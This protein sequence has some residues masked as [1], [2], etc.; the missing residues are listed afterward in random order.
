MAGLCLLIGA[1]HAESTRTPSAQPPVA[2]TVREPAESHGGLLDYELMLTG[3]ASQDQ[4]LPLLLAVHGL[5]GSPERFQGMY[6]AL[7]TPARLV[8]PRAPLATSN[9]GGSWFFFQLDDPDRDAFGRRLHAAAKEV[10]VLLDWAQDHFPTVGKP[11]IT[12]FSQGGMVSLA[13]AA[14]W[15]GRIAAAVAVAGDLPTILV[16][17]PT[18]TPSD[19][20]PVLAFHGEEDEVVPI[21]FMRTATKALKARGYQVELR[22]YPGVGHGPSARMR[23]DYTATLQDLLENTDQPAGNRSNRAGRPSR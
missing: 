18:G 19:L 8:L 5:G 20:P 6:Q 16:H 4:E 15:P 21:E 22:S 13:V 23:R 1:C 3:G 7:S 12:G 10:V 9:G 2:T 14:G 11:V 17:E